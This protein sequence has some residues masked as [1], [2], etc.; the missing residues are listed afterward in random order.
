M[1]SPLADFNKIASIMNRSDSIKVGDKNLSQKAAQLL[2]TPQTSFDT[3]IQ[4]T[5]SDDRI[6][7]SKLPAAVKEMLKKNPIPVQ[8]QAQVSVL[9]RI[10][11]QIQPPQTQSQSVIP[12]SSFEPNQLNEVRQS[13]N[14]FG[15]VDYSLIKAIFDGVCKEQLKEIMK[16]TISE[17]FKANQ[18]KMVAVSDKIKFVDENKE[19]YEIS[20]HHVG[21]VSEMKKNK[22]KK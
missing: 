6:D 13:N 10:L 19:L 21:N 20:F 16:E 12:Q 14:N 3:N 7:S 15:N 4:Q 5:F 2:E 1:G 22:N 11:P 18:I 17:Y 9:D 8:E